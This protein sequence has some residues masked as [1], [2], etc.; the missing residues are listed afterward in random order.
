[1]EEVLANGGKAVNDMRTLSVLS[2]I[3]KANVTGIGESIIQSLQLA[4][5]ARLVVDTHSGPASIVIMN[6]YANY[7]KG[8][9][10]HFSFKL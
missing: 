10:I 6:Q 1:M 8:H 4:S 2:S 3:S 9:M 7:G 5:V